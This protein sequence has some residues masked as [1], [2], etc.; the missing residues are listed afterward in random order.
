MDLEKKVYKNKLGFFKRVARKAIPY[1]F[2]TGLGF[3]L[4]GCK[5]DPE[6][7]GPISVQNTISPT[8]IPSGGN[9]YWEVKVTNNG[10]EVTID[11]AK[12]LERVISGWAQ[13]Q[14]ASGVLP[15][16]N[17]KISPYSTETIFS[18]SASV[19]NIPPYGT[20]PNMLDITIENTVTV[21]SDGGND[22]DT[23][24]YTIRSIYSPLG[25]GKKSSEA[26]GGVF[27]VLSDYLK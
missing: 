22:S 21:S 7:P 17:N 26:E 16:S 1:V 20:P 15:I 4:I 11:Q 13:G 12:V 14:E 2:V 18:A 19:L 9:A 5:V 8:S 27:R 6:V 10:E 3:V 23:S 25:D 24:I